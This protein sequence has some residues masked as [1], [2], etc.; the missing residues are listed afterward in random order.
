MRDFVFNLFLSNLNL[1]ERCNS[2][3]KILP[4][5][6]H[7]LESI[8]SRL[9]YTS[10]RNPLAPVF[11]LMQCAQCYR[12]GGDQGR[13]GPCPPGGYSPA[14]KAGIETSIENPTAPRV[15]RTTSHVVS[16]I[17]YAQN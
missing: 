7:M 8:H 9:V 5:Y 2:E 17:I 11:A 14:G 12:D 6:C 1:S 3:E 15:S 10:I 13:P 16:Y 4:L